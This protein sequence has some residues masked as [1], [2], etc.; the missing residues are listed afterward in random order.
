MNFLK[1]P[2]PGIHPNMEMTPKQAAIASAF[3]N[4]LVDLGVVGPPPPGVQVITTTPLFT[5]PKPGQPGQWRVIAD[6][7][8]GG[9]NSAAGNDPVHLNRPL[10]ILEQMCTGGWTAAVDASKFFHQFST[11]PADQPW[12]GL[13]HPTTGELHV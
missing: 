13:V 7:L 11:R 6:M 1:N 2:E 8:R 5:V 4:E 10:H 12:L 9:Q 3:V